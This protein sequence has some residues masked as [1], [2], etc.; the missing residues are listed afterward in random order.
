MSQD[1]NSGFDQESFL[2]QVTFRITTTFKG[3]L[4]QER[5]TA[6][7]YSTDNEH[8][9]YMFTCVH[10]L[11]GKRNQVGEY[12]RKREDI[13]SVKF[14]QS[15]LEGDI[16]GGDIIVSQSE[17]FLLQEKSD[18]AI[19]I[20]SKQGRSKFLID[21][22][23]AARFSSSTI[24]GYPNVKGGK[25]PLALPVKWSIGD[26]SRK[27]HIEASSQLPADF[28][29]EKIAGLSGAGVF[30]ERKPILLGLVH[31]VLDE[32]VTFNRLVCSRFVSLKL[33]GLIKAQN[34][35]L[36]MLISSNSMRTVVNEDKVVNLEKI[37]I[38]N[39]EINLWEAVNYVKQDLKDDWFLDPLRFV[40]ILKTDRI[41]DLVEA[42]KRLNS[43]K[44]I[45]ADSF[46]CTV[47]KNDFT[48]RVAIQTDLVDR[49]VFHGLV[50]YLGEQLESKVQNISYSSRLN[51]ARGGKYFFYHQVEQWKKFT[52]KVEESLI[53]EATILVVT[54]IA[55]FYNSI[56]TTL[57]PEKESQEITSWQAVR[58][59]IEEL[60][61][62]EHKEQSRAALNA[63][64]AMLS[65]WNKGNF[66]IPQNRDSSSY[67]A[68]LLLTSVDVNMDVKYEYYR[69]MD[70]IRIICKDRFEAKRA[71]VDLSSELERQGFFLN[72]QKTKILGLEEQ[73]LLKP[74]L[75]QSDKK[76]EQISRLMKAKKRR[77]VQIAVKMIDKL[78]T[79]T[80]AE[81]K[82]GKPLNFRNFRF[83]IRYLCQLARSK[84][85]S[86]TLDFTQAVETVVT[87]FI[88]HPN[89]TDLYYRFMLSVD[90]KYITQDV[91]SALGCLITDESKNVYQSQAYFIWQIFAFH[92]V[93]N[94]ELQRAARKVVD[95][96]DKNRM[97]EVGAACIYLAKTDTKHLS[98]IKRQLMNGHFTNFLTQRCA[99]IALQTVPL[100]LSK[101]E[102]LSDSLKGSHS[103][104]ELKD[105]VYVKPLPPLKISDI[106]KDIP[107]TI[108]S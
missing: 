50:R 41:Y 90:K 18:V 31:E 108:D 20:V 8:H 94:D 83:C 56:T 28:A 69:F 46:H 103:T 34:R 97:A 51:L 95:Q 29:K 70:D 87:R 99:L 11:L 43:G 23:S 9:D 102:K 12:P 71:L 65:K 85:L 58:G 25:Q 82:T 5:G 62:P 36:P 45:S 6:V 10:C 3:E 91:I 80:I 76:L 27:F 54:D 49:V 44:Y 2:Q 60:E 75:N 26:P 35:G 47:P 84:F 96:C 93:S 67:L 42:N 4:E 78:F 100:D 33:N 64:L 63:I 106:L 88:D 40:D 105:A 13:A 77:D 59:W 79:S 1:N 37:E 92:S 15:N 19:V 39:C 48:S 104:V 74:F 72:S 89:A 38:N 98:I 61:H 22:N 21:Y 81:E 52:H 101:I 107:N 68:N 24:L 73:D 32:Q 55:H 66:G 16:I 30:H 86:R 7:L 17:D 57:I 14:D 53:G